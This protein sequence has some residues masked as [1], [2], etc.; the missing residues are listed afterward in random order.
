LGYHYLLDILRK[1]KTGI[2]IE[3]SESYSIKE[4]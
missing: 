4:V 3:N 2:L 1:G